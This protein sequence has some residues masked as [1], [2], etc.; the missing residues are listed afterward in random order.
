[1][2][3]AGS[4]DA[5]GWHRRG[6]VDRGARGRRR[7]TWGQRLALTLGCIC[8][9]SL[10]A[11]AAGLGYVY[12]KYQRLPRVELSGVLDEASESGGPENYLVVGIESAENLD[13]GDPVRIGRAGAGKSD[14]IMIL[15][16][17][18]RERAAKLL[19]LPRDL[20]VP[21][22][23]TG[24]SRKIN[25]AVEI[26]GAPLLIRT[27][28]QNFGI[29]IHHYVQ[30]DFAA[31][32]GLVEAIGGV[33][34]YFPYP[35]RDREIGLDIRHAGCVNLDPIQALAFVRSRTYEQLIDGEWD[36]DL[37][38]PDI[39]RIGR[40]QAFIRKALSRASERGARNP[41]T[42]DRLI[43]VGLDGITVD[44]GL[45]AGDLF[46][47]GRRF[48]SFDPE[49]L[50]TY[51]LDAAVTPD[52]VGDASILRLDEAAAA[53]ILDLFREPSQSARAAD[54]DI[55]PASV[56]LRVL[57][58]TGQPRA[59]TDAG[60]ALEAVGF[61]IDGFGDDPILGNDR[62]R[63]Q[64]PPGQE[65]AADLVARWLD[66]G[67]DLEEV[68]GAAGIVLITGSDWKGVRDT[69]RAASQ[70]GPGET[71]A[72]SATGATPDTSTPSRPAAPSTST[73]NPAARE[74]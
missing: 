70:P 9:L 8:A 61:G 74:C 7:R 39:G 42:L 12:R 50:E 52:M 6:R 49:N 64:Y 31:F 24:H 26:G 19:S 5:G 14:T 3:G 16:I 25:A 57:N 68:E 4:G 30:V 63:V 62:T 20:W 54:G 65:A 21:I 69:A 53:P 36:V 48:R 32:R 45:T 28:D 2:P 38:L 46:D 40:Q 37:S 44:Q 66:E 72:T 67:A 22:A 11:S 33:P 59:A 17:D 55:D 71:T 51:S 34:I 15:R 73:T 60:A 47:L 13:P 18:P 23:G 1:M 58:G 29:D 41:G 56:H 27:I 35:A 10:G 43:D